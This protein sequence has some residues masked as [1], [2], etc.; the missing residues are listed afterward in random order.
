MTTIPTSMQ[1]GRRAGLQC[2]QGASHLSSGQQRLQH[3]VSFKH[4]QCIHSIAK[5]PLSPCYFNFMCCCR[6]L[7]GICISLKAALM[8]VLI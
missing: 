4:L 3:G 5:V 2:R 7:Q 1:D 6:Q 8:S